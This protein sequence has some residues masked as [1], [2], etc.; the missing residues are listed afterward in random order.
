[1]QSQH[2][3]SASF[4]KKIISP[5]YQYWKFIFKLIRKGLFIWQF[6][7]LCHVRYPIQRRVYNTLIWLSKPR[8]MELSY[9][10]EFQD[11]DVF[12]KLC[13]CQMTCIGRTI[14]R[15]RSIKCCIFF[16]WPSQIQFYR[17][18][19]THHSNYEILNYDLLK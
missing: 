3:V 15:I 18:Y 17:Q 12:I 10:L 8:Q 13:S 4:G 19:F 6:S 16:K 14:F 5:V 1:M 2:C 9:N 11:Q 7:F